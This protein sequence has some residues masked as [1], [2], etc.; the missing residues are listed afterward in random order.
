MSLQKMLL[1]FHTNGSLALWFCSATRKISSSSVQ[2][3]V[4]SSSRRG[5][6]PVMREI[7]LF[8]LLGKPARPSDK[9]PRDPQKT[10]RAA[11]PASREDGMK[12]WRPSCST[13]F[14]I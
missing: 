10:Q 14:S 9:D 7:L 4:I 8:V 12:K 3:L 1:R 11:F 13:V 5:L 6:C 2:D